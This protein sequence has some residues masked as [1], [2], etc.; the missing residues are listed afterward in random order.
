M[1]LS[2]SDQRLQRDNN[3]LRILSKVNAGK[4]RILRSNDVN[5]SDESKGKADDVYLLLGEFRIFKTRFG[6]LSLLYKPLAPRFQLGARL[7]LCLHC[8]S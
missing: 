5:R 3:P 6:N 1:F 4:T 7:F 2:E 8:Q